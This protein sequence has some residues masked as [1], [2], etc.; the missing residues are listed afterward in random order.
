MHGDLKTGNILVVD[1]V[2]K[3][4]DFGMSR[5]R[6]DITMVSTGAPFRG[7]TLCYNAPE[8]SNGRTNV[9][10]D[11]FSFGVVAYAVVSNGFEPFH[12]I[13]DK[14]LVSFIGE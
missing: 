8:L 12:D 13:K 9:K 1:G 14:T 4:I 5:V 10:T 2:A 7:G 11:I 3:I 6:T